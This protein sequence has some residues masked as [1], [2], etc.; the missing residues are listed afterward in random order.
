M[1]LCVRCNR[2]LSHLLFSKNCRSSDGRQPRCKDCDKAY[3]ESNRAK[4]VI[5]RR[6]ATCTKCM[7]TLSIDQFQHNR[8]YP[9]HYDYWCRTCR[10]EYARVRYHKTADKQRIRTNNRRKARVKW[11]QSL[12]SRVPCTDCGKT[13]EPECM[14]FDH[15]RGE[16]H[17][18]ISRMVLDNTPKDKILAEIKKCEIVCILCHNKRTY[19]RR[20]AKIPS[21]SKYSNR[22][23]AIINKAK[24]VPC[25]ICGKTRDLF[26]M[27]LDHIRASDKYKNISQLKNYKLETLMVELKKCQALCALCH[28]QKS[29]CDQKTGV[30]RGIK[31]QKAVTSIN[32]TE[33]LKKCARCHNTLSFDLFCRHS[34][35][36]HGI[37]SWC[38]GCFNK[39]R[40]EK[41]RE[42]ACT[43]KHSSCPIPAAHEPVGVKQ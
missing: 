17:K 7:A 12:K 9:K 40:K 28:R 35:S 29:I 30:Y 37:G 10:R 24:M 13:Y 33:K 19:A 15:V 39:Y 14:D 16:K 1:K 6:Q 8:N 2:L 18:S 36:R 31:R 38:R 21:Y 27:H 4:K 26:N 41:R 34:K 22:N 3:R 20:G 25:A 23:I 43:T 5:K 42:R 32:A 11:I